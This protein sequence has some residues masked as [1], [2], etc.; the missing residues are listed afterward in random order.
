MRKIFSVIL[1]IFCIFSFN[2]CFQVAPTIAA[3]EVKQELPK[4]PASDKVAQDVLTE[5]ALG[6]DE[7]LMDADFVKTLY[8]KMRT[9][10]VQILS[11]FALLVII[12][13]CI[14][15]VWY[16]GRQ[17]KRDFKR[18]QISSDSNVIEAVENFAR[19]RIK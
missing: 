2:T 12:M 3:P 11:G 9:Y 5:P 16:S 19:H 15:Y 18:K 10:A 14:S 6:E 13:F 1:L 7:Q 4:L 17:R 8:A